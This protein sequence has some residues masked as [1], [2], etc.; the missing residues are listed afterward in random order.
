MGSGLPQFGFP[1]RFAIDLVS[2]EK[3][4]SCTHIL[5]HDKN[6]YK[7]GRNTTLLFYGYFLQ[8]SIANQNKVLLGYE[9]IFAYSS[10]PSRTVLWGQGRNGRPKHKAQ[11][12]RQL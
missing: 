5:G 10:L 9:S 1:R 4:V 6:P 11:T 2:L 3:R 7:P 8:K 12:L